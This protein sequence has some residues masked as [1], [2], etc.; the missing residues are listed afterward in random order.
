MGYKV[1]D[2]KKSIGQ[3]K[4]EID[5]GDAG[6]F[7]LPKVD[8]LTGEQAEKMD[9]AN[10]SEGGIYGFLDELAPGLG[11]AL[12]PL[13]V[14]ITREA[15]KEWQDDAGIGVGESSASAGS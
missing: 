6:T 4:F 14:F 3:N 15:I 13:P 11:S 7:V 5:L 1:P 2:W 12:R 9:R 10:E 8:Y